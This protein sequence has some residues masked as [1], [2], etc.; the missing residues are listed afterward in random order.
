[1]NMAEILALHLKMEQ[2]GRG[3]GSASV[4]PLFSHF[5]HFFKSNFEK[6]NKIH[7]F[8]AT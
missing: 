8:Q 7:S 4:P 2:Q 1:M 6:Y 3:Q 5:T